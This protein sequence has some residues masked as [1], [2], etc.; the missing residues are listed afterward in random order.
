MKKHTILL[1]VLLSLVSCVDNKPEFSSG[2]VGA[3]EGTEIAFN[4]ESRST[5]QQLVDTARIDKVFL[6]KWVN[7]SI[8]NEAVEIPQD[9][10]R[11][12]YVNDI[13]KVKVPASANLRTDELSRRNDLL[14]VGFNRTRMIEVNNMSSEYNNKG[15]VN[16]AAFRPHIITR[17]KNAEGSYNYMPLYKRDDNSETVFS[18]NG[19][20]SYGR[21]IFNVSN[22]NRSMFAKTTK[23]NPLINFSLFETEDKWNEAL[24]NNANLFDYPGWRVRRQMVLQ[25]DPELIHKVTHARNIYVGHKTFIPTSTNENIPHKSGYT[26]GNFPM[27]SVFA[28]VI[29]KL[30]VNT[31]QS[32]WI[33]KLQVM[34]IPQFFRMDDTRGIPILDFWDFSQ[35]G[36]FDQI[37]RSD[38]VFLGRKSGR[39]GQFFCIGGWFD[40][41][42]WLW[43]IKNID[44]ETDISNGSDSMENTFFTTDRVKNPREIRTAMMFDLIRNWQYRVKD[45]RDNFILL[46]KNNGDYQKSTW[47]TVLDAYIPPFTVRNQYKEWVPDIRENYDYDESGTRVYVK[48]GPPSN[49]PKKQNLGTYYFPHINVE[50]FNPNDSKAYAYKGIPIGELNNSLGISQDLQRFYPSNVRAGHVYVVEISV[51]FG[52]DVT[53]ETYDATAYKKRNL[54]ISFGENSGIMDYLKIK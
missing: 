16:G 14:Y 4:I 6:V 33:H 42:R 18:W 45:S 28:R 49:I 46:P 1:L 38:D 32:W 7:R 9:G 37:E 31:A 30:R 26:Y 12:N 48:N 19:I 29:I 21:D 53:V 54:N 40:T 47:Q 24:W 23:Q 3:D 22:L 15:T 25:T 39:P 34:Q 2:A 13:F 11:T 51:G 44:Y 20:F 43:G 35:K 17:D 27:E 36:N 50:V 41:D 8:I 5:F 10:W 52:S